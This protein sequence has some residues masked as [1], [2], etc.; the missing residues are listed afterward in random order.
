MLFI[1]KLLDKSVNHD[2]KT[3]NHDQMHF[4]PYLNAVRLKIIY[5]GLKRNDV[6]KTQKCLY[7]KSKVF[8]YMD[9]ALCLIVLT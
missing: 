5:Y 7:M 3:N 9:R 2:F 8:I 1:K 4:D 6:T